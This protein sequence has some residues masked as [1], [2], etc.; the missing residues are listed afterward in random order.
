MF[1]GEASFGTWFYRLAVNCCLNCR[2]REKQSSEPITGLHE[3]AANTA[4]EPMESA[5]LRRQVQAEVHRALLS[6]KPKQRLLV[7]L[8]DIEGLSYEEIAE[9][10]NYSRGTIA[11]RLNRARRLLA[12]KLE[13]LRNS[14]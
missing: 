10:T 13:R 6:L 14:L 3:A 9:R 11:S 12:R 7:V 5:I 8:R 1:R 2:R 4:L